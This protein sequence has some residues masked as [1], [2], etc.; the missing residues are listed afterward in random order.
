MKKVGSLISIMLLSFTLTF[1]SQTE[2][3]KYDET[4]KIDH[5]VMSIHQDPTVGGVG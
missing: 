4:S 2:A 5:P 3:P 1:G